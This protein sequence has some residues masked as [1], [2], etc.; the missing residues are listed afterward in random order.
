[1]KRNFSMK[2]GSVL[3]AAVLLSGCGQDAPSAQTAQQASTTQVTQE[4]EAT[5]AEVSLTS[6]WELVEFTVNGTTSKAADMDVQERKDAPAF[7]CEDGEH[8][9]VNMSGKDHNGTIKEEGGQQVIH[10]DNTE[11]TMT[12]EV[13][14]NT[15]TLVNDKGTVTMIFQTK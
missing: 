1:M 11:V 15:L 6:D 8:C 2:V 13:S 3:A 12:A 9:V 5:Q 10:F 14:G 4:I 7:R